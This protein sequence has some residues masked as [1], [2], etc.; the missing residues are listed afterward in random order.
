VALTLFPCVPVDGHG[1]PYAFSALGGHAPGHAT[2]GGNRRQGGRRDTHQGGGHTNGA[3][4]KTRRNAR[5]CR[6]GPPPTHIMIVRS[7]SKGDPQRIL[8]E[9]QILLPEVSS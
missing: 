1:R 9:S 2:R 5:K 6:G 8:A 4:R 3:D 7:K